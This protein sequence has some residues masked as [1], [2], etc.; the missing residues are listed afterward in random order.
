[1]QTA[2][3]SS[4]SILR[5]SCAS[6]ICEQ[7]ET[8]CAGAN[9]IPCSAEIRQQ[10]RVRT[11]RAE[12]IPGKLSSS[13]GN[14]RDVVGNTRRS[15]RNHLWRRRTK[16]PSLPTLLERWAC[17]LSDAHS[18]TSAPNRNGSQITEGFRRECSVKRRRKGNQLLC[19]PRLHPR[20]Q[21][22]PRGD[23]AYDLQLN[24]CLQ[25]DPIFPGRVLQR[26]PW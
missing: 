23:L 6:R 9:R 16:R 22:F 25:P 2:M 11:D 12:S 7:N 3:D 19:E 21:S 26:S 15:S 24:Y 14:W 17:H 4:V 8:W 1:M 13:A 20:T 10:Q 18:S 5:T